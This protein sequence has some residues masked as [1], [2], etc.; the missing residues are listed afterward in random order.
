MEEEFFVDGGGVRSFVCVV[1]YFVCVVL[2]FFF[3]R[4]GRVL[5]ILEVFFFVVRI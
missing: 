4:F 3:G 2:G 5:C 1:F